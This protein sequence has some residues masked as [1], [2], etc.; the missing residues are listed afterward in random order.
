MP[1]EYCHAKPAT[2]K[3]MYRQKRQML[4]RPPARYDNPA[5]CR[6]HEGARRSVRNIHQVFG[7]NG[8]N[9]VI[10]SCR[11]AMTKATD[12]DT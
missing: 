11:F 10:G 1:H 9:V 12:Q 7:C 8:L 5:S 2:P 3:D 4:N 6:N